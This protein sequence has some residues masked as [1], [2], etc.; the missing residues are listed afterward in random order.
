MYTE[1]VW[2]KAITGFR[3]EGEDCGSNYKRN[4][5]VRAGVV[6]G[7]QCLTQYSRCIQ[8]KTDVLDMPKNRTENLHALTQFLT[9]ATH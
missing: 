1:F 6:V 8:E 4:S 9:K 5:K 3:W 7:P 2:K